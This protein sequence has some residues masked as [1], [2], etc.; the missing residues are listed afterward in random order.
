MAAT[1]YLFPLVEPTGAEPFYT[2]TRTHRIADSV[3]MASLRDD[4][5]EFAGRGWYACLLLGSGHGIMRGAADWGR[6]PNVARRD[7]MREICVALNR[8]EHR[9]GHWVVAWNTG[10]DEMVVLWR[11]KDGDLQFTVDFDDA[12][13]EMRRAPVD[14]QVQ[15]CVEAWIE[16]D[17]RV[18]ERVEVREENTR[19][20][21]L[22]RA[23]GLH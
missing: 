18:H 16:W 22:E 9:G 7:L 23:A 21:A 15:R 19:K 2:P 6:K 20:R 11:D 12:W 10:D 17:H 1:E 5:D 4:L 13:E 14:L 3:V 8:Q